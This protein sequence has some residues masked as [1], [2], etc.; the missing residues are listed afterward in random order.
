M[1]FAML[2]INVETD[3][4]FGKQNPIS[5]NVKNRLIYLSI[6][7]LPFNNEVPVDKKEVSLMNDFYSTIKK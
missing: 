6:F 7:L 1:L 2:T 4:Y 5:D 3:L